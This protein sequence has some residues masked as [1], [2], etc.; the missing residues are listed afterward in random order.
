MKPALIGCPSCNTAVSRD[1]TACPKCGHPIR[2]GFLGRP[3]IER[4]ISIVVLAVLIILL[5]V[6]IAGR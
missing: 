6:F 2:R 1:A 5:L 4:N 3:G